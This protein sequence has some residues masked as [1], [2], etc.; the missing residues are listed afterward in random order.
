MMISPYKADPVL[1]VDPNAA[2]TRA[3][4]MQFLK[5]ISRRDFQVI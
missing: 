1:I 3:V 2:L 5:A 4:T